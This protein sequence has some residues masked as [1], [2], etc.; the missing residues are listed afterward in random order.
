[1]TGEVLPMT[2]SLDTSPFSC[3]SK[4]CGPE[5]EPLCQN[6]TIDLTE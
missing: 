5:Y 6:K 1:M 4:H 2:H 3:S